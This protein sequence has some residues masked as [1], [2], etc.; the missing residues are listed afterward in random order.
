MSRFGTFGR[1]V[2]AFEAFLDFQQQLELQEADSKADFPG[3]L[4]GPVRRSVWRGYQSIESQWD[5][6]ARVES[7]PDFRPQ[8]M[9]GLGRYKG[10]GYVGDNGEYPGGSRTEFG[11]PT[12]V[13]DTYGSIYAITRQAIINDQSG[14]LLNRTPGEMG[15]EAGE[16]I[17]EALV[18][19]IEGNPTAWDGLP[20][21]QV[22][23]G[24]QRGNQ[25]TAALSEDSLVDAITFM[26][27]QR[28]ND[29]RRIRIRPALLIVQN[30]RQQLIADRIINSSVTGT[31]V[32]FTGGTPGVGTTTF[33]KGTTNVLQGILPG[34]A[35]IREPYMN[36]ANDW[37]LFADVN[38]VPAFTIGFLNGQRRPAV[39]LKDPGVRAALGPGTDPYTWEGDSIDFKV[40][41]DFGVSTVDPRGTYR[42]VVA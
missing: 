32:N 13:I 42:G 15:E 21:Y 31:T 9:H 12:L 39:F 3:W 27:Q 18:A 2:M 35:V 40:R 14:A 19:L 11:G 4:W 36:D 16:F 17:A 6:Y 37:Y 30:A 20:M 10:F 38:D 24:G 33:D 34:N 7:L 28:D 41:I 26:E 5:R 29:N 22:A 1:P 8:S 25:V 23:G